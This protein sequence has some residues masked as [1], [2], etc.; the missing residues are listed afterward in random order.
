MHTLFCPDKFFVPHCGFYIPHCEIC[1]P[2]CG[3]CIPHCGTEKMQVV[4]DFFHREVSLFMGENLVFFRTKL[5][6]KT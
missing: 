2:Q 6:E 5:G 4:R 1:I 3:F